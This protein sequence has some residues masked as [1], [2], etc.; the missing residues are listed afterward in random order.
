MQDDF[1]SSLGLRRLLQAFDR[2][3]W[4]ERPP[5]YDIYTSSEAVEPGCRLV[6]V[7]HFPHTDH[8]FATMEHERVTVCT[9]IT[10]L[11]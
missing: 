6:S 5:G 2:Q 9:H 10:Y 11:A 1:Q 4:E 8:S 3:C 7:C